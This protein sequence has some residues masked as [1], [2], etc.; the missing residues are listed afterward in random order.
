MEEETDSGLNLWDSYREG[1]GLNMEAEKYVK[2]CF[3]FCCEQTKEWN[4]ETG[5]MLM[6][7]KQMY[8]VTGEEKYF[9][10]IESCLDALITQ[11]GEIKN[12]PE[13]NER[14]ESISCGRV[15]YFMYD[16][17]KNEKYRKA[18]DFVM[19]KLRECPRCESGNFLYQ[20]EEPSEAWLDALYMTQPF[21]MEYETKYNKKEKYNDIINQFENV[22]DFLYNKKEV[23]LRSVGKYL[24]ALIDAM[25]NM[26]FE[27][28][29]QYRKLQDNFKLTL[30]NIMP[31]QDVLISYCIMKACRMGVLLKE[32]YADSAMKIIENPGEDFSGDAEKAGIFLMA[33][34]QYLQLNG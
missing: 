17:T 26:S 1:E 28:Y 20:T 2:D 10:L 8:E 18:I 24:A 27:I 6:G 25:D 33:Y 14:I 9:S 13:E 16:K 12:Y 29:E 15:L 19:N 5:V 7:A 30:K 11:D 32:K 31:C 23:Q 21:Y 4:Y 22:Q 3:D 34:S